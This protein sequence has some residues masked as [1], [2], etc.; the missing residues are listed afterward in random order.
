[1]MSHFMF[2]K[3]F[4]HEANILRLARYALEHTTKKRHGRIPFRIAP[5]DGTI[6]DLLIENQLLVVVGESLSHDKRLSSLLSSPFVERYMEAQLFIQTQMREYTR[7]LKRLYTKNVSFIVLKALPYMSAQKQ[8]FHKEVCDID[9]LVHVSDFRKAAHILHAFDYAR[10][11]DHGESSIDNASVLAPYYVPAQEE[12]FYRHPFSVELHT[13]VVHTDWFSNRY[14][15][16]AAA[17]SWTHEMAQYTEKTRFCGVNVVALDATRVFMNLFIHTAYHHNFQSVIQFYEAAVLL[18]IKPREIDWSYCFRLSERYTVSTLLYWYLSILDWLF[19][20][21]LPPQISKRVYAYQSKWN[22]LQK[23]WF[24]I[25]K[26]E[27]FH[28]KTHLHSSLWK[29]YSWMIIEGAFF[30]AFSSRWRH[31][32]TLR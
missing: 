13:T 11:E 26:R 15:D 23:F 29:K 2:T 6:L 30:Q 22:L 4:P 27:V 9:L 17:R 20:S 1:M 31:V 24:S 14:F 25:M 8:A 12:I 18:R 21:C 19:P 28:P 10:I 7:V 32:V 3:L 16:A 5:L